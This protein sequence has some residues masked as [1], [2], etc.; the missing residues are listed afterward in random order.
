[1]AI[2]A[3]RINHTTLWAEIKYIETA[4]ATSCYPLGNK[5][6]IMSIKQILQSILNF[7]SQEKSGEDIIKF[8][9]LFVKANMALTRGNTEALKQGITLFIKSLDYAGK[10][11]GDIAKA[12]GILRRA[13]SR[14]DRA[15]RKGPWNRDLSGYGVM[16][17]RGDLYERDVALGNAWKYIEAVNDDLLNQ[18]LGWKF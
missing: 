8:S 15:D 6:I 16:A 10:Y 18:G 1:M 4:I 9:S 7:S 3:T 11:E 12:I 17:W 5:E 14:H 2:F 13:L